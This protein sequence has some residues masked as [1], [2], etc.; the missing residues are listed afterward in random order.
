MVLPWNKDAGN[1]ELVF[2]P[3][4]F[5]GSLKNWVSNQE[6]Q[7]IDGGIRDKTKKFLGMFCF[8]H[9]EEARTR[10]LFVQHRPK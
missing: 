5:W 3:H 4:A 10:L 9:E 2:I 8:K 1:G 7:N 6:H